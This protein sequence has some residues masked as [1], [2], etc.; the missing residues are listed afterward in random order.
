ME[1]HKAI[2]M[3]RV[4][5]FGFYIPEEIESFINLI[6]EHQLKMSKL[7]L[8]L[9]RNDQIPEAKLSEIKEI[10][11]RLKKFEPIQYI[12]GETTFYGLKFKVNPSVL[13]PRPETEELVDWILEDSPSNNASVLDIGTGSGCIS[14]AISKN[15]PDLKIDAWDISETA[16]STAKINARLNEVSINFSKSNILQWQQY[17][18]LKKYDLIVSNPPYVTK[19]EKN[20]MLKN[21]LEHEPHLALFVEDGDPLIFYR[22]IAAFSLNYL[23]PGGC[24]YFEINERMGPEILQ[25]LKKQFSDGIIRKDISGK[26]RMARGVKNKI[27]HN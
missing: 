27:S 5:L 8:H 3:I 6:F 24:I 1:I 12:L 7:Q 9:H 11:D 17:H 18:P 26:D 13:I 14:I 20:L 22:E 16:L 21:V 10:V 19:A 4:T 15:R 23:N 25:I 2:Q